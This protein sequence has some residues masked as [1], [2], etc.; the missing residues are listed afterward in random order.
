MKIESYGA[1]LTPVFVKKLPTDLRLTVARKVPQSDWNMKKILEVFL[2]ELE[3]RER[4][5]LPKTKPNNNYKRNR[6]YPTTRTFMGGGHSGCCYC[7]AEDH[8][9]VNCKRV[10]AVDDR[11]R[12]IR[13]QGRCFIC[14]RPG[15][16]S[17]NCR[18]SSKC[19]NCNGRHHTSVCFKAKPST[20]ITSTSSSTNS[21]TFSTNASGLNPETPPFQLTDTTMTCYAGVGEVI[22]LQTARAFAFNLTQRERRIV[23]H[24]LMDSGSQCS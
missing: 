4:A 5:A 10:T 15:H 24:V 11:K 19:G 9:P 8:G 23:V 12:I 16:I 18:S 3:A 14:L 22:M 2:E 21:A 20:D 1:L 17:R 6:D 7:K 13:E